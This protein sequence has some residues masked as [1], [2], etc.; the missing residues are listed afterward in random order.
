MKFVN[1][2]DAQELAQRWARHEVLGPAS[3]T[4]LNLVEWANGNSDGW[5]YWPRPA[6]AA[7][8]LM[9]LLEGDGSVPQGERCPECFTNRSYHAPSCSRPD[10]TPAALKAA[11]APVKAFRTRMTAAGKPGFE[12]VE[13]LP[14][15]TQELEAA[16]TL[17]ES[18][19]SR[20]ETEL[21]TAREQA[22]ALRRAVAMSRDGR[23]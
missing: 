22:G 1:E 21:A 3:R 4:L 9:C 13:K 8:K 17:K 18:Q 19:V 5:A 2:W 10:A 16:L 14:S 20:L 12:V 7:R 23:L 15:V 6:A 11:L